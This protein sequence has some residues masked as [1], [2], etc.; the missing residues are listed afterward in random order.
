[1]TLLHTRDLCLVRGSSVFSYPD[2]ILQPGE[3]QLM[4]GP[5]GSG[6]TTLL[7]MIAGLLRPTQGAIV[8]KESDIYALRAKE[9]DSIRGRDIGF[10]FQT[11]HLLPFLTLKD[12]ILL[13]A[14][15]TG[16]KQNERLD[17]L[18]SQLNL[19]DKAQSM[20][21]KLSQGEKQRAAIA[22][23]VLNKPSLILADEP[24]SALDHENTKIVLDLLQWQAEETGAALL[25]A[26]HDDRI[27]HAL[28]HTIHLDNSRGTAA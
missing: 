12:N 17:F 2:V 19:H 3:K 15:M 10:I 13:A 18:L 20:P 4:T 27:M 23:A 1:M 7:S 6:K 24:T 22:R 21:D 16:Q 11:L 26:T 14:D 28:P 5:S 25:I 8:F 9:R